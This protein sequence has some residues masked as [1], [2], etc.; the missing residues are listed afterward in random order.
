MKPSEAM[1]LHRDAIRQVVEAN[2]ARNP[3]V[4]GSALRGTDT[5]K[6]D[7]DILVD[8]T[9][10]LSLLKLARISRLL[11]AL[12]GVTVDVRTPED[13][14]KSFRETVLAEAVAI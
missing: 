11:E 3:R 10:R 13:L 4:F 14:P 2:A 6:S 1:R 9:A 12:L 8:G 5:E 7:L